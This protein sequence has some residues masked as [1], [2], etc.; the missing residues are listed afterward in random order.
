VSETEAK[1][2]LLTGGRLISSKRFDEVY[3]NSITEKFIIEFYIG[4]RLSG[5]T[6]EFMWEFLPTFELK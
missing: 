2:H 5:E 3:Y 6:S 4:N 1:Q